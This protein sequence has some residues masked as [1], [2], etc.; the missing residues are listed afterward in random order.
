M[1]TLDT[2]YVFVDLD[3]ME[4]N[5]ARLQTYLDQHGLANRPHI[6]THKIPALARR[7]VALGAVGITCQK[8]G[9]VEVMAEAGLTDIFLP[10]NLVG[11]A[12]LDRLGQLLKAV[13]LSLTTDSAVVA[14]GLSS[15]A[16]QAGRELT[17]LVECDLG[18][19]RCGVQSPQEAADLARVIA[20]LPGLRFGGLMT[21]PNRS[22]LDDFVG[23]MRALLGGELPIERVSGNN[24]AYI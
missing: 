21:Y 18:A 1:P 24:S 16:Q 2:P 17:I 23:A 22:E 7:Q 20:R 12:K 11:A 5:L 3:L 13:S 6:K 9:E 10:Y 14:K 19:R 15:A 4:A 8:L